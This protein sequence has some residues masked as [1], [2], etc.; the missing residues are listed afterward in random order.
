MGN[1]LTH[2][3]CDARGNGVGY[4]RGNYIHKLGGHAVG[5]L[6]GTRVHKLL[7][8][9]VG[10]LSEDMVVD[11]HLGSYG[12]IGYSGNPGYAANPGNTGNRSAVNYGYH[13]VLDELLL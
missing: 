8:A 5:Q 7:R 11:K 9:Y 2:Y 12:N 3:I 4:I 6:N 13:G 10:E 1:R